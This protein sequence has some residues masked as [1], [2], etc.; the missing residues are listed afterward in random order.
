MPQAHT[1]SIPPKD[2]SAGPAPAS[3]NK[4]KAADEA[5]AA[6]EREEETVSK[7]GGFN[8]HPDDPSNPNEVIER[9]RRKLRP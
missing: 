3:E 8:N 9:H 2:N 1:P 4:A 6:R 7:P 5:K